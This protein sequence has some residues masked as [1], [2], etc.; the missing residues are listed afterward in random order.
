MEAVCS[1]GGVLC[2]GGGGGMGSLIQ[3]GPVTISYHCRRG[4]V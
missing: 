1:V 2:R 3:S 4:C